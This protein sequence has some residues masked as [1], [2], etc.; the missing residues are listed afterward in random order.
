MDPVKLIRGYRKVEKGVVFKW[1]D[2]EFF[3]EAMGHMHA[4]NAVSAAIAAQ[5]FGVAADV[6]A[7]ALSGFQGVS[8]R[9]DR[10]LSTRN[11]DVYIDCYGYLP[12]SLAENMSALRDMHP[13]RRHI[14]IYQL[15]IVDGIPEAQ[16]PLQ[17]SLARWDK[18]LIVSYQ[19]ASPLLVAAED[20]Y[21]LGLEATLREIGCRRN[22]HRPTG[23]QFDGATRAWWRPGMSFSSRY[24]PGQ[25][26]WLW[27]IAHHTG[28]HENTHH[29]QYSRESGR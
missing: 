13:Q 8:G 19:S 26:I 9:M 18:V 15:L 2:A 5:H 17:I 1:N 23:K 10:A 20:D 27:R 4:R 22:I 21:L 12:E 11:L 7:S 3:L 28:T 25:R 29:Q 6:A 24:I 14:L 16:R